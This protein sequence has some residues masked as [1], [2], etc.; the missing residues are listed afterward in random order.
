MCLMEFMSNSC[1]Q[2]SPASCIIKT[3]QLQEQKWM[4]LTHASCSSSGAGGVTSAAPHLSTSTSLH[5]CTSMSLHLLI[6][7]SPNLRV[8]AHQQLYP[9][10]SSQCPALVPSAHLSPEVPAE[11]ELA[12]LVA[13]THAASSARALSERPCT[14]TCQT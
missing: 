3:P 6:S 9:S 12:P 1:M 5:L 13:Q 4:G 2:C 10:L 11:P 8:S 7:A 14:A